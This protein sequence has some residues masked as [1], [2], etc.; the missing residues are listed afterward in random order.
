MKRAKY[1]GFVL[2]AKIRMQ[3]GKLGIFK[4]FCIKNI[5]LS[6]HDYIFQSVIE[7]L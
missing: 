7:K 2:E 5:N 1:K 3:E 4:L 6:K